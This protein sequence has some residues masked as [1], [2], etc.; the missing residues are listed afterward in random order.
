MSSGISGH[1]VALEWQSTPGGAWTPIAEV[2]G[3]LQFPLYSRKKIDLTTINAE[4]DRSVTSTTLQRADL[5]FGLNFV[6]NEASHNISTGL[7]RAVSL[8]FQTGFRVRYP[9]GS[10]W[11][12]EGRVLR[13][14]MNAP[15]DGA[16][17]AE[18]NI[19]PNDSMTIGGEAASATLVAHA[20]AT[21]VNG[22]SAITGAIDTTPATLLVM[23][24]GWLEAFIVPPATVTIADSEFN[25]WHP[26]TLRSVTDGQGS[27]IRLYY[28]W[29]PIVSPGHTFTVTSGASTFPTVAVQAFEGPSIL[30]NPFVQENGTFQTGANV[31]TIPSGEVSGGAL[32]VVAPTNIAGISAYS[33]DSGFTISDQHALVPGASTGYAAAY[34]LNAVGPENPIWTHTVV[35]LRATTIAA[36]AVERL[37]SI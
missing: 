4:V 35:G 28:A 17:T 12:M 1:G 14:K 18:V 21:S 19:T 9:D 37:I 33:I 7:L 27:R 15:I 11:S 13:F 2:I 10:V 31:L 24:A 36:F 29:N 3:D 25:T 5:S 23:F 6:R 30:A 34:K 26:L 8:G 20:G 22:S 32:V 16:L